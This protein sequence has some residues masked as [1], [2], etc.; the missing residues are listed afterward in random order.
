IAEEI[1]PGS[2]CD[3]D[4]ELLDFIRR[5]GSTTYHPVGTCRMGQDQAVVDERL[6]VRGFTGLRV[7]CLDHACGRLGKYQRGHNYDRRE[8]RG[9]DTRRRKALSVKAL[10]ENAESRRFRTY[11]S[12]SFALTSIVFQDLS[13]AL[14]ATSSAPLMSLAASE[15]EKPTRLAR[16]SGVPQRVSRMP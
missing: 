9:H 11:Q 10:S 13:I 4:D 2:R 3:D 8:G 14:S 7:G 5:R 6:R 16:S 1:E 12:L 15:T